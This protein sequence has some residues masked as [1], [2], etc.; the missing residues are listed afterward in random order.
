MI[1]REDIKKVLPHREPF[2][3]IDEILEVEVGKS[4]TAVWHVRED[5]FAFPGHFPG[6]PVLPGVLMVEALAQTGAYAILLQE[7][8]KG[9]LALFG[10]IN[11]VKFRGMVRPGDDL[12]L[13]SELTRISSMGGKAIAKATVNGKTICEGEIMFVFAKE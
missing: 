1:G 12:I 7:E 5:F 4:A 8:F 9:K 3:L 2:L 6:N 10:G 11:G 13:H